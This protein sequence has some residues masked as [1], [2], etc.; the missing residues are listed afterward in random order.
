MSSFYLCYLVLYF[1]YL[2]LWGFEI[3]FRNI[4]QD[5]FTPLYVSQGLFQLT[6]SPEGHEACCSSVNLNQSTARSQVYPSHS[7]SL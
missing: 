4:F 1:S 7:P 5:T 2:A 6:S 3:T